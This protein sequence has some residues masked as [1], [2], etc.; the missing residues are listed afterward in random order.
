MLVS[1]AM[2]GLL[3]VAAA[4]CPQGDLAQGRKVSGAGTTGD[5]SVVTQPLIVEEGTVWDTREAVKVD[6]AGEITV[7]LGESFPVAA[8]ILQADND[9]EYA[10]EGSADGL[11]WTPLWVAEADPTGPGLRTR[12][13]SLRR[14]VE[15]KLLRVRPRGG[16]GNYSVARLRALCYVPSDWANEWMRALSPLHWWRALNNDSMVRFKGWLALAGTLLL[17]LGAILEGLRRSQALR[18]TRDALLILLAVISCASWFN[19]MHFHFDGFVHDWEFFHYYLGAKYFPEIGYTHLY[20]CTT[21]AELELYGH[22]AVDGRLI[23]NLA[24]NH[25]ESAQ[26]VIDDP[27]LCIRAFT[28]DRWSAFKHDV[29][30]FRGRYSK[31]KWNDVIHDHGYNAT[32]VW[33]LAGRFFASGSTATVSTIQNLALLDPILLAIMWCF[34][35]WAF[36]WRPTAVAML[37]WGTN[38]PARYLWNGGAYLRMDWLALA[39]IGVSMVRKEKHGMGGFALTTAALLRVFP[40]FIVIGLI[41]K[42]AWELLRTKVIRPET[43]R[44][45]AGCVAS[46]V[47]LVPIS[48]AVCGLDAYPAFVANSKKH[49]A[50]ALTNNMGWKT[51]VAYQESTRVSLAHEPGA[52]DPFGRWKADRLRVFEQRKSIFYAGLLVFLALLTWSVRKRADWLALCLGVGMIPIASELTC[53]YYS[54]FLIFGFLWLQ[55]RFIGIALLALSAFTCLMA[56]LRGQ[57]DEQFFWI[58]IA[59]TL[60]SALAALAVGRGRQQLE[61][62]V[63]AP[64]ALQSAPLRKPKGRGKK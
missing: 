17:M 59:V 2:F 30:Y 35:L 57:E 44:F 11:A 62:P 48:V 8:L 16:D 51:W 54:I 21:A 28:A 43:K 13:A 5:L 20:E 36:G 63:R 24:T 12:H 53:Y 1:A 58:S 25:L 64:E 42:V 56:N 14:P 47:I 39:V 31:E 4:L 46:L 33:G 7:D 18:R 6:G 52:S 41:C 38:Y 61:E 40:G 34:A 29:T 23:R 9:D 60:F 45:V 26:P 49:L 22:A 55:R 37:W 19:L 15:L 50:T 32:P 27:G 3:L 10:I